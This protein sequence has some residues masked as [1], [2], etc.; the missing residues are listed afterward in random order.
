M[1]AAHPCCSCSGVM[2]GA[3][4][5]GGVGGGAGASGC[6]VSSCWSASSLRT[7]DPVTQACRGVSDKLVLKGRSESEPGSICLLPVLR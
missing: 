3:G 7:D 1:A 4:A 2:M 5:S 6:V